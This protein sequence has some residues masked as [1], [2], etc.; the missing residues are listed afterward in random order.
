MGELKLV[1]F[2][3]DGTLVDSLA[4]IKWA[5]AVA[6]E[7]CDLPQPDPD[8]VRGIIG[9]SLPVAMARLAPGASDAAQ[10]ALVLAYSEAF[11]SEAEARPE[12]TFFPGALQAVQQLAE[13]D[14]VLL[15]IATGKSRRGM[16]R[17]LRTYRL[18]RLFQTVQVA[19]NH[20][21]KPHPSM[22]ETCLADTGTEPHQAVIL[23]D[24]TFDLEMGR[25][26]GIGTIGVAWGYHDTASLRPHAD[27]IIDDYA[28]L[29]GALQQMWETRA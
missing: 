6:F 5:M 19:D 16:D 10:R 7:A 13:Q 2:D 4:N 3:V 1:I 11:R 24:T 21:S 18:E 29:D 27:M 15:G 25:S 8:A 22:I 12:T 17:I 20:P 28:A 9:L 14:E 26:A 23:G